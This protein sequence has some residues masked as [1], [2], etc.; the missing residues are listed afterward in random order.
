MCTGIFFV[1]PEGRLVFGRTLEFA[2]PF[3]WRQ[4]CDSDVTGTEGR[5]EARSVWYMT[6]GLNRAGLLVASFFYPHYSSEYAVVEKER[7]VNLLTS[8]VNRY[9][10]SRCSCVED[11][12]RLAPDLN[13]L[14]TPVGSKLYSLH[15]IVCDAS[16]RCVVLEVKAERLV[17]YA[18]EVG[19]LTNNPSF[20]EQVAN[21]RQYAH[22]SNL[23]RATDREP[24]APDASNGSG[25]L[26]LPG[27]S[28]SMSRFVRAHFFLKFLE[29]PCGRE[30]AMRL[31]EQVLHNF[32]IPRGTVKTA[33]KAGAL[34]DVTQYTVVY[35]VDADEAEVRYAP[36]GTV[37]V[38]NRWRSTSEPVQLCGDFTSK[39]RR[40]SATTCCAALALLALLALTF[41]LLWPRAP[42]VVRAPRNCCVAAFS[43]GTAHG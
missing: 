28:T 6:D 24:V 16:C 13:V 10:S 29:V 23:S 14:E 22:L 4:V 36:Y 41:A 40:E 1:T 35:Y 33:G 7:K 11:V 26:G 21:L 12:L 18:N 42:N 9:I 15:W 25:A 27:D 20:P 17:P 39:R 8:E 3:T 34:A 37:K 30:E 38:G 5:F 19:V 2:D 31:A 43:C 32:D